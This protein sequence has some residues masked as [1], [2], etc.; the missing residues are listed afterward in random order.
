MFMFVNIASDNAW[1]PNTS[2]LLYYC[3]NWKAWGETIW[4]W[5]AT[6]EGKQLVRTY[7][8][9]VTYNLQTDI[10]RMRIVRGARWMVPLLNLP[11]RF[12]P[13]V[14]RAGYETKSPQRCTSVLPPSLP[15][16]GTNLIAEPCSGSDA[17]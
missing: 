17:S 9:A 4:C 16:N 15:R 3:C 7:S 8:V 11:D 13:I 5:A 12:P 14:K 6:I 2:C 10:T 1:R